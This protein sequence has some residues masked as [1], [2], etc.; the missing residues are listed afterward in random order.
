MA[1]DLGKEIGPLPL[2]AWIAV[3]AGGLGIAVWSRN[4]APA[5]TVGTE[6]VEDVGSPAGVGDGSVGGW[7]PTVPGAP[8]GEP[9]ITTN[10]QWGNRSINWLIAQ[11]YD[12]TWCYSAITKA[13]AGGQ[14]ENALS[15]REYVLWGLALTKFGAPPTPVNVP[16][17]GVTPPVVVPVDPGDPGGPIDPQEPP[18]ID[19]GGGGLPQ[20]PPGMPRHKFDG[21]HGAEQRC[22]KL[23]NGQKC[24][25]VR[26]RSIHFDAAPGTDTV[27]NL[28]NAVSGNRGKQPYNNQ[29]RPAVNSPAAQTGQAHPSANGTKYATVTAAPLPGSTLKS[30][31]QIHYGDAGQWQRIFAANRAGTRRADGTPG[32][33]ENPN[34]LHVGWRLIIPR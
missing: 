28:V 30:L 1:L 19:P 33:I 17:P 4:T 20:A 24:L 26:N 10:E 14:G 2:G 9:D 25:L 13:L 32:L 31:A 22:Q 8:I 29:G 27:L 3:I 23:W 12:P 16:P 6:V 18:P 7:S 11:G 15:A 21:N 34:R 5:G